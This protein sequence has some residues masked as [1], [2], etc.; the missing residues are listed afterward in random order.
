MMNNNFGH[1]K[2]ENIKYRD[3]DKAAAALPGRDVAR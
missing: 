3:M 1:H 2:M